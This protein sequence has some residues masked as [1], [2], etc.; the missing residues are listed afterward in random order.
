MSEHRKQPIGMPRSSMMTLAGDGREFIAVVAHALAI[1]FTIFALVGALVFFPPILAAYTRA[2]VGRADLPFVA[3]MV[4]RLGWLGQIILIP[5]VNAII[6]WFFFKQAK[7]MW[8]GL[9][10]IPIIIYMM[11]GFFIVLAM[12]IPLMGII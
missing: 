8:A 11:L 9:A 7:R 4:Q 3:G 5:L 10:F 12:I 1:T 2:G 6:Y